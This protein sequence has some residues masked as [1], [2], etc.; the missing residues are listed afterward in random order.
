MIDDGLDPNDFD[1]NDDSNYAGKVL[2]ATVKGDVHDIAK[3]IV[4]VVLGCNNYKV[5]DIGVMCSCEKILKAAKEYNVDVIGLS[6]LITPSL[7]EMVDVAKELSK[8]GFK[9]PLLIGGAT[10]SKMHT[11]V[12]LAPNYFTTDHPVIHVLDAS[13]SVTVV[14]SLLGESKDEFVEDIQE[15]YEE[16]REDYYAGLEDRHFLS[17]EDA[18]KQKMVIDFDKAPPAPVPNK[19]GTTVIDS[20]KLADVIPYMDWNPF[21]Q[22]WELRGRYPNRGY[23]KIFDDKTVGSEAKKLFDDA[24]TM[25]KQI[26][27][28]ESMWLKGIVNLTP[29]NRSEDGEDVDVFATEADREAGNASGKYCMLRQQA[30]KESDDPYLSQADYI[31]PKGYKDHIGFFA[32][33]CFG[34]DALVKKYEAE[35]DD[36]SKIMAQALADRFV[37]AFAEYL[38]REIRIDLWGYAKGESLDEADLLKIKYDGIRPAPG[39]PSQPDHTEKSTMWNFVKVFEQAGIELSESLS[40]MP[41]AS[42]SALVFAHPQSD[43]FAVGQVGKDQI[44]SY[45]KRKNMQLEKCE[46]WLSPILNYER[47]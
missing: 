28:D 16:M 32:V 39:Y 43:Y 47:D 24:Q 42:V 33:S 8:G 2:M 36:F 34:C 4:A 29:A 46:R 19:L 6:G 7:D 23:P 31:A 5:Y 14:S 21:F 30:E 22:T 38:H 3:N 37:E 25:L 35:N 44:E 10:T 9:Q 11:A 27:K 12:K 1:E 17:H 18:Q 40:M 26:V 45:A 15:E 20:V 41:A 13:R